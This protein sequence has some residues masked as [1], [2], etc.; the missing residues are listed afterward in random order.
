MANAD[1][2]VVDVPVFS[3]AFPEL[4]FIIEHRLAG[5]PLFNLPRLMALA[6]CLPRHC[7]DYNA[8]A[9]AIDQD[10]EQAP[11][12]GLSIRETIARIEENASWMVL[13]NVERDA[14]YAR[15][16]HD[17]LAD[18]R[19]FS[20][21]LAPGMAAFE[22]FIFISSPGSITP[23]HIDPEHNFLAQIS[24]RKQVFMFDARDRELVSERQLERFYSAHPLRNLPYRDAYGRKARKFNLA[25][26]QALYLPQNGPHWVRN[27]DAV[28]ISFS[29][30]FRSALSRRRSRLY[31]FNDRL[32]AFG[33]QPYPVGH[34][35]WRDAT[36]DMVFRATRR[37]R[38]WL[39]GT[40]K[41]ELG[42]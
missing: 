4:P 35:P 18:V 9:L 42:Y 19:R 32:R 23:F 38:K 21:S 1:Y 26:G 16:L 41:L 27:G 10:P 37:A 31:Q 29:M 3:R 15:L 20:E 7:V 39:T 24:G 28:S 2:M 11:G 34:S 36:K 22:G 33:L 30:T 25:P 12:N 6:R 17:C 40:G 8:G 13:K 5:H 14:Q